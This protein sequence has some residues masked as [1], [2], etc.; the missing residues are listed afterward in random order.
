MKTFIINL[1][2][3]SLD[4]SIIKPFFYS[5]QEKL[6]F[7]EFQNEPSNTSFI[8][9]IEHNKI[10]KKI[11]YELRKAAYPTWQIIFLLN[12]E[13]SLE[14]PE[15]SISFRLNMIQEHIISVLNEE[16]VG[17][18]DRILVILLDSLDRDSYTGTPIETTQRLIWDID[19]K[20]YISKKSIEKTALSENQ[21]IL[22]GFNYFF[23]EEH[24]TTTTKEW[25]EKSEIINNNLQEV[26]TDGGIANMDDTDY[27]KD[28]ISILKSC[29]NSSVLKLEEI[30]EKI[31]IELKKI[32]KLEK[33][34]VV[35][36]KCISNF[37][38]DKSYDIFIKEFSETLE[39]Y[40]ESRIAFFMGKSPIMDLLKKLLREYYSVMSN[41][42]ID[43]TCLRLKI[44]NDA[45]NQ[46]LF[47]NSMIELAYLL[48]FL[49][50]NGE[51]I[52]QNPKS[53]TS[54]STTFFYV[55]RIDIDQ[56]EIQTIFKDYY[57]SLCLARI[58]NAEILTLPTM[59]DM[60]IIKNICTCPENKYLRIEKEKK[61]NFLNL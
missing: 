55:D 39:K 8:N 41:N 58:K 46:I 1:Q 17:K 27:N 6:L 53:F 61:K 11:I 47:R 45:N 35:I 22:E 57:K 28:V 51:I 43:L 13:E 59:A 56:K 48:I 25:D 54:Y 26:N 32:E 18:P 24:L 15:G 21:K 52:Y 49:T 4:F 3:K 20:G 14:Y 16:I 42:Y 44:H 10:A 9:Q 12:I 38:E 60:A 33:N 37:F 7:L 31:Q 40:L 2:N 23:S 19:T 50:E 5:I 30:V 36:E 29:C 34:D